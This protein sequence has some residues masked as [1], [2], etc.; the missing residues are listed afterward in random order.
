VE[1]DVDWLKYFRSIKTQCPWSYSAYVKGQIDIV[2]YQGHKHP[3]GDYQAR[4]YLLNVATDTVEAL[5]DSMAYDDDRDEWLFSYPGYGEYATA[6]PVL[7]QQNK[8]RLQQL[9]NE[10]S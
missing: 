6:V 2:K 9:R 10:I 1:E 7:I 5:C 8:Q 4:L 3:L